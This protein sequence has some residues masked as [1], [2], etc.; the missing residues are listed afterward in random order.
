MSASSGGSSDRLAR[1]GIVLGILGVGLGFAVAYLQPVKNVAVGLGIVAVCV[2][3]GIMGMVYELFL[4]LPE[5][6]RPAIEDIRAK[7]ATL[8]E[9]LNEFF[10]SSLDRRF[11]REHLHHQ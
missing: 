8:A 2:L 4:W 3:I 5:R 10:R 1:V 11:E 9:D 6:R 7:A